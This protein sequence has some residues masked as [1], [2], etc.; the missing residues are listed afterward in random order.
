[1]PYAFRLSAIAM[2]SITIA[3]MSDTAKRVNATDL[4]LVDIFGSVQVALA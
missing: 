4:L 3:K 1:M 2:T